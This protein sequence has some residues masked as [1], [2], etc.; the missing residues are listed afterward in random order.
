MV[1]ESE[2]ALAMTP[3]QTAAYHSLVAE[4]GALF[5]ARHYTQYHFLYTLSGEGGHHGLEHHESSDNSVAGRTVIDPELRL[6]EEGLPAHEVGHSWE[7]KDRR[8]AG[9]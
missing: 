9:P 1:S 8:P 3:Q 6:M 4:A 7:G 2:A 5:G